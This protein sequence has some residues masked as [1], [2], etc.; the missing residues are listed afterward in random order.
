M[1]IT[2]EQLKQIIKEELETIMSE[3][4]LGDAKAKVPKNSGNPFLDAF[5]TLEYLSGGKASLASW[6]ANAEKHA[7]EGN[8]QASKAL[9]LVRGVMKRHKEIEA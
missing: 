1:K 7:R 9:D 8:T 2:K 4:P 5:H 3:G 6:T